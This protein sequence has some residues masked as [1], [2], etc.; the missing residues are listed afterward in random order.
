MTIGRKLEI[1]VGLVLALTVAI[2]SAWLGRLGSLDMDRQSV[3]ERTARK[4]Q[5]AAEMDSAGSLMLAAMR[6]I[7]LF[8][9]AGEPSEAALSGKEFDAAAA[10]W[11]KSLGDLQPLLVQDDQAR[12]ASQMQERLTAWQLAVA[13]IKRATARGDSDAA[14]KI[15]SGQGYPIYR[16]IARDTA[17]LRQIQDGTLDAQRASAA[18]VFRAGWWTDFGALGLAAAAGLLTL[19]FV[20]YTNRTPRVIWEPAAAAEE[21]AAPAVQ[22]VSSAESAAP[23]VEAGTPA[24]APA[25]A[26]ADEAVVERVDEIGFRRSLLSLTTALEAARSGQAATAPASAADE[27]ATLV[28]RSAPTARDTGPA[29]GTTS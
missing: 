8:T 10:S 7:V 11:R 6:G 23:V 3:A 17:R 18:S 20:H 13:Q 9:A 26:V 22:A 16:A 28:R 25:P 24:E 2:G 12:L 29:A 14:L 27:A 19:F 4:L 1:G 5:I 15:A 21:S